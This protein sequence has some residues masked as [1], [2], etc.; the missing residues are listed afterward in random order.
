MYHVDANHVFILCSKCVA[1]KHL[2]WTLCRSINVQV[3]NQYNKHHLYTTI[4][5]TTTVKMWQKWSS[6]HIHFNNF[7]NSSVWDAE[8]L[9]PCNLVGILH[10]KLMSGLHRSWSLHYLLIIGC[11]EKTPFCKS[12]HKSIVSVMQKQVYTVFQVNY[13][14]NWH[15]QLL[16]S[17]HKSWAVSSS[18]VSSS[19]ALSFFYSEILY[20]PLYTAGGKWSERTLY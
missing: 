17:Y 9:L 3:P 15:K 7:G 14:V 6:T 8:K 10:D 11:V 2:Q 5:T 4:T 1:G 16:Y 12:S 13:W 19:F 18:F 20:I